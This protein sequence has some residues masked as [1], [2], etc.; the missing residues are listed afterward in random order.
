VPQ[1]RSGQDATPSRVII[2]NVDIIHPERAPSAVVQKSTTVVIKG[3]R[4][5][6]IGPSEPTTIIPGDVQ[7][8]EG[9]GK[10]L[11]PGFIDTH[12]HF[13]QSGNPYTRPDI[14]DLSKQVPYER[15]DAR[16]RD[17]LSVTFRTWLACGVTS[18]M[19]MGGP[20]WNFVVREE[21]VR[22]V[23]APRVLVA[24]PLF[25]M[26]AR[27]LLE[28]NDPPIIKVTNREDVR[29]LAERQLVKKPNYLKVWF[30]HLP[31][32]NLKEQEDIVRAVGD[33][34][35]AAGIPLA[36]HA[37]ELETAK[38][39]LRAGADILVHSVGDKLVDEEFLRLASERPIIYE[40]TLYVERGYYEVL[41]RN[42]APTEA[43][44]RLGDPQILEHMQDLDKLSELDVPENIR[45]TFAMKGVD[46]PPERLK[47][48]QIAE[49]NLIRVLE[50]G[51]MV[52]I[53][54]D[55]GNI[56]TIHGPSIFREMALM[57]HAGLTPAQVL[58]CATTNGAVA[59]GLAKE[60]G[61]VARG[62]YADLVILNSNPLDNIENASDISHVIRNGVVFSAEELWR[63]R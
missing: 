24:G 45:R 38:S 37:T 49:R 58:K 53:G 17:R 50:S 7:V 6:T 27:P 48:W 19:D 57:V 30:I 13:F 51:I 32:H 39:A 35:H 59:L 18:V 12:I 55:A 44:K 43:E 46:T 10:W 8:I 61:R 2:Q 42:W 21:A 31:Q 62:Y 11:L 15:E 60:V 36:V 56:G 52:T 33:L 63:S 47:R 14:V 28:L 41:S 20:F 5:D 26:V 3:V 22:R 34:A 29:R 16:N 25:S 54:T 23:D 1:H 9:A 4:I 40:P